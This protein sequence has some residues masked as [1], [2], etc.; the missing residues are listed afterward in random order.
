V[1]ADATELQIIAT[2]VYEHA[3]DDLAAA[4]AVRGGRRIVAT[5]TNAGGVAAKLAAN[6][7]ADLVMTS[8]AGIDSLAAKGSVVAASKVDVGAMRLGLAVKA[9]AALPDLG[10]IDAVR[11]ALRAGNVASIDPNGGGT[12]GP[13]LAQLFERLGIAEDV[14]ARGVLCATGADVV[15]AVASARATIGITQAAELIGADGVAFAGLL[16]EALQL[17]TIYAAAI[18]ADAKLPDAAGDFLA[19]ITGPEGAEYLRRLGWGAA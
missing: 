11:A 7:R 19:F 4:Y 12:S 3:L 18:G 6:P 10:T 16:P 15:R 1:T 9:G 5:I 8:S 2:G 13:F 17:V 14:R